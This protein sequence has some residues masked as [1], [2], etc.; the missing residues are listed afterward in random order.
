MV[1]FATDKHRKEEVAIKFFLSRAAFTT[2]SKLYTADSPLRQ[3]LPEIRGIIGNADGEV[4]DGNG[5]ALPPCIVME[6]G[7]SLDRWSMRNRRGMDQFTCMQVG[8]YPH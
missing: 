5:R 3:F 2:E 8:T 1:Q 4:V 6:K 7:E